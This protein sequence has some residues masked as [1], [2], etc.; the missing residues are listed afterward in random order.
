MLQTHSR[1]RL[2]WVKGVLRVGRGKGHTGSHGIQR[3][4]S[5]PSGDIDDRGCTPPLRD[6]IFPFAYSLRAR[7]RDSAGY[8]RYV[9]RTYPLCSVSEQGKEPP[10]GAVGEC[11]I[12]YLPLPRMLGP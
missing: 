5:E 10:K 11:G 1:M 12:H 3:G 7:Y 8:D 9:T 2:G 4:T 6:E